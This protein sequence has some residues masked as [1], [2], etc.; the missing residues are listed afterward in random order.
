MAIPNVTVE[1]DLDDDGMFETDIS[2]YVR[3][4]GEITFGRDSVISKVQPRSLVGMLLDNEDSR[5]S[6]DNTGSPYQSGGLTWGADRAIRVKITV[7]MGAVTNL[8]DNPSAENDIVGWNAQGSAIIIV[9][10]TRARRGKKC[11]TLNFIGANSGLKKVLRN[12]DRYAVTAGLSYAAS[13]DFA[14]LVLTTQ[15]LDL[16][17]DWYDAATGG[18]Q[19]GSPDKVTVVAARAWARGSVVATAPGGATHAEIHLIR[20]ASSGLS[21]AVADCVVFE[22][23]SAAG[24]PYCDGDLP[25]HSWAGTAHESTSSRPAN[26]TFTKFLGR[27]TDPA[28]SRSSGSDD[29]LFRC[30][31]DAVGE[32]DYMLDREMYVAPLIQRHGDDVLHTVLDRIEAG[33]IFT[34]KH[35]ITGSEDIDEF[36]NV[37]DYTLTGPSASKIAD[38]IRIDCDPGGAAGEPNYEGESNHQIRRIGGMVAGDGWE[39]NLDSRTTA[40]DP[41]KMVVTITKTNTNAGKTIRAKMLDSGGTLVNITGVMPALTKDVLRL[42]LKGTWTPAGTARKLEVTCDEAFDSIDAFRWLIHGVKQAS[43]VVR[44]F[45]FGT[46]QT[47][48]ATLEYVSAFGRSARALLNSIVDSIGGLMWDKGDGTLVF[49]DYLTRLD[50]PI[51]T[52]RFTDSLD[53]DGFGVPP[54]IQRGGVDQTYSRV[55]VYSDGALAEG[56]Q[57]DVPV[58]SLEPGS[59]SLAQDE[60]RRWFASYFSDEASGPVIAILPLGRFQQLTGVGTTRMIKGYGIGAIVKLRGPT[61]GGSTWSDLHIV[62]NSIKGNLSFLRQ[63]QSNRSRVERQA[64]SAS[65]RSFERT[66]PIDMPMQGDETQVMKDVAQALADRFIDSRGRL[67]LPF[68]AYTPEEWLLVCGAEVSDPVWVRHNSGSGEFGINKAYYIEGGSLELDA[69]QDDGGYKL[70]LTM[71]LDKAS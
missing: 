61:S 62:P 52:A 58:W 36:P 48:F 43:E 28:I 37:S 71:N 64:A 45:R 46:G 44:E 55:V 22:Q 33:E 54:A 7:P 59:F 12:G 3:S 6:P 15:D 32:L 47:R 18:S 5:F 26:P 42:E 19:V 8:D 25:G 10:T 57:T 29:P 40:G 38:H 30:Q 50:A 16:E 49:E 69:G 53:R 17:I 63:L 56:F 4:L 39:L 14:A 13:I 20:V 31:V 11:V 68:D 27:L 2:T 23:A 60:E 21:A 65:S 51:P 1:C 34:A 67:T 70:R 66:L 41:F 9:D 35:Q 24:D